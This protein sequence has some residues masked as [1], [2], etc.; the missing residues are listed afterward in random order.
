[1]ISPKPLL[2]VLTIS[3]LERLPLIVRE[4]L[5]CAVFLHF[6]EL[7]GILFA[8]ILLLVMM[9]CERKKN[10]LLMNDEGASL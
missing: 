4:L 8:C 9:A 3:I 10:K 6:L 5:L 2:Q 1:M 7:S